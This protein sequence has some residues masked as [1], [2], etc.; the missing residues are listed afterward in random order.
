MIETKNNSSF[1]LDLLKTNLYYN[2]YQLDLGSQSGNTKVHT[3]NI[4][5]KKFFEK[6][7]FDLNIFR[8][9]ENYK[10]KSKFIRRYSIFYSKLKKF[11][12]F[13]EFSVDSKILI[14]ELKKIK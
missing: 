5:L 9:N 6:K 3:R 11:Y 1:P 13:E 12:E 8:N 10:N 7:N 2:I 4:Y 14:N